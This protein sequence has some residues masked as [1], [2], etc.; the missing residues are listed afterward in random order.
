MVN[1]GEKLTEEDIQI[2]MTEADLDKDGMV[3]Y[4]EFLRMMLPK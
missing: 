1:L 3:D 4:E 2:M